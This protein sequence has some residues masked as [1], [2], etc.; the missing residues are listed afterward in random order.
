ML[1]LDVDGVL[2]P[3]NVRFPRQQ[4]RQECLKLLQEIVAETAC[5]I[6]LSTSWRLHPEARSA[7]S[8][9]LAE[10]GLAFVSRTPNIAQ[11]R[12]A[13]EILAWVR[14]HR[15]LAWVALDDWPLLEERNPAFVPERF[16]QTRPRCGL[17]RD[18]ADAVI[19]AFRA[20]REGAAGAER[21]ESAGQRSQH[22]AALHA[23][24]LM[25]RSL[26]SPSLAGR[27]P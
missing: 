13:T 8:E 2:H 17:Q 7:L 26:R 9:K 24:A 1:F 21:T 22:E 27:Q 18:A 3:A 19:S 5:A 6:V 23:Y 12:R 4:F 10:Y 25:S 20:Q 14:K 11:F 15:P 16:V